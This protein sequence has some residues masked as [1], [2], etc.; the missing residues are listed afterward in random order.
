MYK[1]LEL[2]EDD[3]C[4]IPSKFENPD[5]LFQA[6]C[7]ACYS[8]Q[9]GIVQYL[10]D[11]AKYLIGMQHDGMTPLFIATQVGQLNIVKYF[12]QDKK[13]DPYVAINEA[14]YSLLHE[15]AGHCHTEIVKYLMESY[16]DMY[17]LNPSLLTPLFVATGYGRLDTVKYF[18]EEKKCDPYIYS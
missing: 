13:C 1:E 14:G 11:I 12:I 3:S 15:A 18:I 10:T 8:G 2:F 9:L 7:T 5:C 6:L 17:S 4:A 16:S